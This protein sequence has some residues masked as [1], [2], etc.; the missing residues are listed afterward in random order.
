LDLVY[1]EGVFRIQGAKEI[2]PEDEPSNASF[3]LE[4]N[5]L[6]LSVVQVEIETPFGPSKSY[7]AADLLL[8]EGVFRVER[9]HELEFQ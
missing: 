7:Y 3:N 1:E 9:A 2:H 8:E 5:I 4:T 6:R